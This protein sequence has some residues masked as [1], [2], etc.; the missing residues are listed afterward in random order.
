MVSLTFEVVNVKQIRTCA[1]SYFARRGPTSCLMRQL[2][3]PFDT[4]YDCSRYVRR[5]TASLIHAT[6]DEY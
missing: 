6:L 4:I 2:H 1:A 3:G 5:Y